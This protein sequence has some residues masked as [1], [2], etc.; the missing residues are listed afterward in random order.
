MTSRIDHYICHNEIGE[1]GQAVV[2][3]ATDTNTN[4]QVAIKIYKRDN[5]VDAAIATLGREVEAFQQLGHHPNLVRLLHSQE[6]AT[7]IFEDG[8]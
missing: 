2:K 5:G 7:E 6:N 3:Q 8:S 1:G 4:Q